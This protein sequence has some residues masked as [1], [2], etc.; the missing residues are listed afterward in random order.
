MTELAIGLV[1]LFCAL[2]YVYERYARERAEERWVLERRDLND[3]IQA[4]EQVARQIMLRD[5]MV[6]ARRPTL[7]ERAEVYPPQGDEEDESSDTAGLT[8]E[9]YGD[10]M[11]V[12]SVARAGRV[13]YL[14]ET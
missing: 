12:E 6:T 5:K 13:R 14:E 7:S 4:P 1:A 3:R 2:L 11:E 8:P 9:V 10:T